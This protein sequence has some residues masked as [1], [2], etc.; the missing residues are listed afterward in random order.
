MIRLN[1]VEETEETTSN[2]VGENKQEITGYVIEKEHLQD[3]ITMFATKVQDSI[4][5]EDKPI[6]V[7]V[8]PKKITFNH[9]VTPELLNKTFGTNVSN[10][11][12]FFRNFFDQEFD[13]IA[14][15]MY[16]RIDYLSIPPYSITSSGN[17]VSY[18]I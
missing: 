10:L 12:A 9:F 14:Q 18:D 16:G 8:Q 3:M 5:I 2:D 7:K 13:K 15:D 4:K 17:I 6:I 11:G 1:Q